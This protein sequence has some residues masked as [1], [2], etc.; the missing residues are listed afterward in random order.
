LDLHDAQLGVD[1]RSFRAALPGAANG[2][3]ALP[4]VDEVEE[5]FADSK[6]PDP[7]ALQTSAAIEKSPPR[8]AVPAE[9]RAKPLTRKW[10][11]EQNGKSHG[12]VVESE[13]VGMFQNGRLDGATLVWT[14]ALN[15]W[16]VAKRVKILQPHIRT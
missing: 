5:L 2:Q 7:S 9:S 8:N 16:V 3:A 4:H 6:S 15:D 10:F 14:E 13:L 12:P 1:T 11:F